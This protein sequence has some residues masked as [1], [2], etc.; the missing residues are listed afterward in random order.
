MDGSRPEGKVRGALIAHAAL[1]GAALGVLAM[2]G[3]GVF[4]RD[5]E[6]L[7]AAT[8][9]VVVTVVAALAVG[10]W[11]GAPDISPAEPRLRMRWFG[12]G[13]T[14]GAAGLIA[15]LLEMVPPGAE[16]VMVQTV[17]LLLMVAAPVYALGLLLPSLLAWA[18]RG[19][20]EWSDESDA[21][22][23]E[24]VGTLILGILA[25]VGFG[26]AVAA[27]ALVPHLGA[28]PV[29]F[30][31]GA[32]LILP[33][34]VPDPIPP[35]TDE[36]LIYEADT[37]LGTVR[38]VEFVYPGERQPE[39]RLYVNDE[40][41]SG[42]LVRSG[43]PTLPYIAAAEEWF[44]RT[45]A[46]GDRYLFLGGGA[47]TLPRRVAERDP[48]AEITVVELDPEI[49]RVAYRYFGMRRGYGIASVHGDARAFVEAAD[50]RSYDRLYVDVYGGQEALPYSIVTVEAFERMA[51]LLRPGGML[52][53]NV[54]GVT[55]GEGGPRLWSVIRTAAAVFPSVALYVHLGRDY[56]DRQNL[57]L[58][59]TAKAGHEFPPAAGMFEAWPR[60]EWPAE[61]T[62]MVFRDL[63]P[64]GTRSG[65]PAEEAGRPAGS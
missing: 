1:A 20:I 49:T 59:A 47:Y 21:P 34:L 63:H 18:E 25:G 61:P 45:A 38:V 29:L 37:P 33:T 15:T 30:G 10:L 24:P 4:L 17:A 27:T 40:E 60:A 23:W 46:P 58:A 44:S 64:I 26:V 19:P 56:P 36:K 65:R 5:A 42:E 51:R 31:T 11:A 39:R 53:V 12:A 3:G 6:G 8:A 57:L 48:R 54:I 32:A 13:L 14:A 35:E 2:V 52:T 9:G 7:L 55:G 41:E 22:V 62:T 43:A 50:E 16:S 28:G